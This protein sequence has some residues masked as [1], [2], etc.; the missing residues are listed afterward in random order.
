MAKREIKLDGPGAKG[1]R[2]NAALLRDLLGL[3]IEGAQRALRLRTQGRSTATGPLPALIARAADFTVQIQKGSTVL[4]LEAPTLFEAD[5]NYFAQSDMFPEL[6]PEL[7]SYDYLTTTFHAALHHPSESVVDAQMVQLLT[8]FERIFKD[9]INY[10]EFYRPN[11]SPNSEPLI[12]R[13]SDIRGLRE[14]KKAIPPP[15]AVRL[16]GKLD[17]IKHSDGTFTVELPTGDKV[18]G[19]TE[20]DQRDRLQQ[21]WG[22]NALVVGTAHFGPSGKILRIE[23][24]MVRAASEKDSQLWAIPPEPQQ[25]RVAEAKVRVSQGPRSGINALIGKWPGDEEDDAILDILE[26]M[27]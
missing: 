27:S 7:T 8:R 11:A 26:Q 12:V 10:M 15:Q 16:A 24:R 5:P 6:E 19:I 2:V 18:K 9:G 17:L 14:L 3:T 21:L 23:A 22:A 13:E 4:E 25:L 20:E 1:L